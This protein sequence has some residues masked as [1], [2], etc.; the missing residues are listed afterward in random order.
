M[1]EKQLP[2]GDSNLKKAGSLEDLLDSALER[3][4]AKAP[5]TIPAPLVS[6]E[7]PPL[8]D[9]SEDENVAEKDRTK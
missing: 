3:K 2:S 4:P 6:T 1:I 5:E 9:E 8:S 7:P